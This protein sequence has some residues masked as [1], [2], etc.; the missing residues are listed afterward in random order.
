MEIAVLPLGEPGAPELEISLVGGTQTK[1]VVLTNTSNPVTFDLVPTD[2]PQ[3]NQRVIYRIGWRERYIGR[4]YTADF[5][6]PDADVNFADLE[7]LGAILGG[8]TYLQWTDRGSV[9]GVAALDALGRVLDG[10]GNPIIS[11]T[12]G[13]NAQSFTASRGI[14]K[15]TA[16]NNGLTTYDF[17]LDPNTAVRKYHGLV[18]PASGN[19]GTII[20]N[21]GSPHVLVEVRNAVSRLPVDAVCRPNL[22]G[23]TIAVEFASPP[24]TGQYTAVVLG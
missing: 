23:N 3:L 10:D 1:T 22:D 20:H 9:N 14:Q 6:M 13:A 11:A 19:F 24:L 8:V 12:G 2:S 17:R 5:V 18:I 15:V 16:T 21:L 7:D 4:Q